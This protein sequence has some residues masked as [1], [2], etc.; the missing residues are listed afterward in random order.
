[1]F[2]GSI[3]LPGFRAERSGFEVQG[4]RF[5]TSKGPFQV[6]ASEGR[7]TPFNLNPGLKPKPA[8]GVDGFRFSPTTR[9]MRVSKSA[10]SRAEG[11]SGEDPN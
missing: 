9:P 6:S 10:G 2:T 5:Y 8:F 1:M 11:P 7:E 3:N 4:D